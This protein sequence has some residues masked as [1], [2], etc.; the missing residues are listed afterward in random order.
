MFFD[1]LIELI[2]TDMSA[3]IEK[4]RSEIRPDSSAALDF[5]LGNLLFESGD[6]TEAEVRYLRAVEKFPNFKRAHNFLGKLHIKLGEPKES[7]AYFLRAIELGDADHNVFG[8][9]GFV[10]LITKEAALAEQYYTKGFGNRIRERRMEVGSGQ[11]LD[12]SR[13]MGGVGDERT[14]GTR[15]SEAGCRGS[16]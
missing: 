2:K 16:V 12:R 5:V 7:I 9:L 13:K 8:L 3:A 1:E 10:Y 15:G 11:G 6:L 14:S 4:L